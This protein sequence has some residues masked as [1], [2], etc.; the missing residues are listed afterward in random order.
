MLEHNIFKNAGRYSTL[1]QRVFK[2]TVAAVTFEVM[3]KTYFP[4]IIGRYNTF[5][6][7]HNHTFSKNTVA[8]VTFEHVQ[9]N[10]NLLNAVHTSKCKRR[11]S[12]RCVNITNSFFGI[13]KSIVHTSK[14][15]RRSSGR[16]VNITNSFL[17]LGKSIVHT[18]KCRRRSSCRCVSITNSLLWLAKNMIPARGPQTVYICK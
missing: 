13:G 2:N 9:K 3:Q 17:G 12:G 1:E 6:Q 15:K 8:A 7:V 5:E 10:M 14:C 18:S 11:S 16:C 4:K